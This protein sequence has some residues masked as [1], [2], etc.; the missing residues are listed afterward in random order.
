MPVSYAGVPLPTITPASAQWVEAALRTEDIDLFEIRHD[1]SQTQDRLSIPNKEERYQPK[2]GKLIWPRDAHRWA[3]G[4]FLVTT[5]QLALIRSRVYGGGNYTP[6]TLIMDDGSGK[7]NR[8][9]ETDL[10]MLPSF[11]VVQMPT[12][13]SMHLLILVDARYFWWQS[14]VSLEVTSGTTDYSDLY[15]Q[16]A[17]VTGDPITPDATDAAYLQPGLSFNCTE[18]YVPFLLDSIAYNCG[19]RIIRLL[20]GTIQAVNVS[21]A[22]ASVADNLSLG[23][24]RMMGGVLTLTGSPSDLGSITPSEV[25]IYFPNLNTGGSVTKIVSMPTPNN[26][27]VKL[28]KSTGIFDTGEMVWT[29]ALLSSGLMTF[30]TKFVA[31]WYD[32]QQASV[33]ETLAG[34]CDWEPTGLEDMIEWTF[35]EGNIST[36]ISRGPLTDLTEDLM[37]S[38]SDVVNLPTDL[39]VNNLTINNS[40]T[41]GINTTEV[42]ELNINTTTDFNFNYP[43]YFQGKGPVIVT[44]PWVVCGFQFW[45]CLTYTSD[46]GDLIKWIPDS[47]ATIYTWDTSAG[48]VNLKTIVPYS[49]ID[50]IQVDTGA[51]EAAT[52]LTVPLSKAVVPGNQLIVKVAG[53]SST[54]LSSGGSPTVTDSEGNTYTK[55]RLDYD[56][57]DNLYTAIFYCSSVTSVA[58]HSVTFSYTGSP[59]KIEVVVEEVFNLETSP[60]DQSSGNSTLGLTVSPGLINQNA[61]YEYRTAIATCNDTTNPATI[62]PG[63]ANFTINYTDNN[64]DTGLVTQSAYSTVGAE[65]SNPTFTF[66]G[67]T[68]S[69]ASQAVFKGKKMGQ[70]I[71]IVNE[72]PNVINVAMGAT[73]TFGSGIF[74]SESRAQS[75]HVYNSGDTRVPPDIHVKPG[76]SMLLWWDDCVSNQWVIL[77]T[78]AVPVWTLVAQVGDEIHG[79]TENSGNPVPATVNT[80]LVEDDF[81]TI[82]DDPITAYNISTGRI[83]AGAYVTLTLDPSG[84]TWNIGFAGETVQYNGTRVAAWPTINFVDSNTGDAPIVVTNNPSNFSVDVEVQNVG[85]TSDT[86]TASSSA[87]AF[88]DASVH[89]IPGFEMTIPPG[90]ILITVTVP[91]EMAAPDRLTLNL[92]NDDDTIPFGPTVSS[93]TTVPP[94]VGNYFDSPVLNAVYYTSGGFTLKVQGLSNVDQ[95]GNTTISGADWYGDWVKLN[96]NNV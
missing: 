23:F 16:I 19:Q 35:H 41:L 34:I 49:Q 87:Y 20:D 96:E 67:G 69:I 2:L 64:G 57:T 85:L 61:Y 30:T 65:T 15:D 44:T 54:N 60:L 92:Y 12:G 62:P 38:F 52:T 48:D 59:G 1:K 42:F 21:T 17:A 22:E 27:A 10:F 76:D 81:F 26:G 83:P 24:R 43:T 58:P 28:F 78:T 75:S 31:D 74:P 63:P 7:P 50:L 47:A 73:D 90:K 68:R 11:P 77:A 51:V 45:C 95:A 86:V 53:Q 72:G 25:D 56:T 33:N 13:N 80:V 46:S 82:L 55:I 8:S 93:C 94:V 89:I 37:H 70:L 29:S 71:G 39:T 79:I 88:S 6:Q 66:S 32:W 40:L 84:E 9:I 36:K 3:T 18:E 5:N 91:V 14:S 4:L